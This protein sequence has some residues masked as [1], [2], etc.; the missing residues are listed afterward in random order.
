MRRPGAEGEGE[1]KDLGEDL[2]GVAV[3]Q[4]LSEV[5]NE[6]VKS[7]SDAQNFQVSA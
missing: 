3:V 6:V 5:V 1:H 2:T 4:S 7:R